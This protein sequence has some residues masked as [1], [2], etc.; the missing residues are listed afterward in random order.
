MASAKP[1][2]LGAGVVYTNITI[3]TGKKLDT[4]LGHSNFRCL[5]IVCVTISTVNSIQATSTLTMLGPFLYSTE[6]NMLA[7]IVKTKQNKLRDKN[8]AQWY[9]HVFYPWKS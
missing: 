5:W 7:A 9:Q 2:L 4:R 6:K 8:T 1:I 3:Y